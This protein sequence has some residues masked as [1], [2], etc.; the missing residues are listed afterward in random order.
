[1]RRQCR[2]SHFCKSSALNSNSISPKENPKREAT[3]MPKLKI[4][5]KEVEVPQGSTIIQAYKAAGIDICHYCWHPGLSVAG[6][7]RLCM[8]QIEGMPK[9]QIACNTEV[10]EGM[11]V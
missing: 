1:M 9:L 7:C 11:V 10:K 3:L 5:G 6:V 2:R 4:N 8:V